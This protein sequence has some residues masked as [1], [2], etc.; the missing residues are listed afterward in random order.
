MGKS[1]EL[2]KMAI[3]HGL[4]EQW[5]TEWGSPDDEALVKK[6]IK[7]LDFCIKHHYPPKSYLLK[8]FSKRFLHAHGI[9]VDENVRYTSTRMVLRGKCTGTIT[10]K[11]MDTAF[12]WVTEESDV[13]I[14]CKNLAHVYVYVHDHA[15][16]E[17]VSNSG[18][19]V[20][21]VTYGD[22]ASATCSGN[23]EMRKSENLFNK[24]K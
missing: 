22:D 1:E 17:V 24:I 14:M 16:A 13:T 18:A 2:K 6:Y 8:K 11:D 3:A 23:V 20:R 21:V 15:S 5:Q 12:V 7:G 19:R 10:F 4:C 9:W